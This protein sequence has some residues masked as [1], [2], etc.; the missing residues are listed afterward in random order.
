MSIWN[1]VKLILQLQAML[2]IHYEVEVEYSRTSVGTTMNG[3][4]KKP[5]EE[6]RKS[7]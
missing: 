1:E 7:N 4:N 3:S 6:M 5:K 2:T